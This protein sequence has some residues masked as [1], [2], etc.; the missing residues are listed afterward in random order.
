MKYEFLPHTA[1]IRMRIEAEN[2]P[3]LFLAGLRG[4]GQIIKEN[5]CLKNVRTEIISNTMV[6]SG[7]ITCLL[8]DFLSDALTSS[9]TEKAVFCELRVM[10]FSEQLIRGE[11]SG[12]GVNRFDEEIKAVTYHEAEVRQN[13]AGNWETII[14]FDI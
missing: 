14:V 8:V 5:H 11:I 1:D 12:S 10:E 2:L 4:M 6:Q 3:L 13:E 7:D 9:Y